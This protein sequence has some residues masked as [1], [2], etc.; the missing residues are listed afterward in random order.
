MVGGGAGTDWN[1][2]ADGEGMRQGI[3][4]GYGDRQLKLSPIGGSEIKTE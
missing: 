1:R 4:E 2:E 3:R